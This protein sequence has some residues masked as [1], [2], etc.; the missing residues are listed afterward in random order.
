VSHWLTD[1]IKNSK[2]SLL[3]AF[4]IIKNILPLVE[5]VM[6]DYHTREKYITLWK[7]NITRDEVEGDIL[8]P[9]CDISSRVWSSTITPSTKGSMFIITR[10]TTSNCSRRV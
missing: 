4:S 8:F 3:L 9:E 1:S 2:S 6:V 7:K 5:G 10:L